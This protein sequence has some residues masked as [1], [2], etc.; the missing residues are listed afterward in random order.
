[1]Q[2][3]TTKTKTGETDLT[4]H[5][6]YQLNDAFDTSD[7][8]IT[9]DL[10]MR[11]LDI[12]AANTAVTARDSMVDSSLLS[13]TMIY[14]GTTYRPAVELLESQDLFSPSSNQDT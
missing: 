1:M 7:G 5:L 14:G 11:Y 9:I 8:K 2:G 13:V 10:P 6:N 3:V 12:Y 4:M